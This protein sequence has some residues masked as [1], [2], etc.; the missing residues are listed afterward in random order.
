MDDQE[1]QKYLGLEYISDP[2]D[3]LCRAGGVHTYVEE[4]VSSE[5]MVFVCTRCGHR[6]VVYPETEYVMEEIK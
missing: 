1:F 3:E 6:S 2:E 5:V 4:Y